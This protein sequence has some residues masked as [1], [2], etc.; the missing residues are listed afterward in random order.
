MGPANQS[1]CD[2][3]RTTWTHFGLAI[4]GFL[5]S[6]PDCWRICTCPRLQFWPPWYFIS[7]WNTLPVVVIGALI[8]YS[9]VEMWGKLYS[10]LADAF[11]T[12]QLLECMGQLKRAQPV[13]VPIYD[14]KK[15][16]WCSESF[17]KVNA[18]DVIIL[19][20]I[21]VFHDQRVRDL[22]DMKIFVDTGS[23]LS[24]PSLC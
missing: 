2:F 23:Y 12:E 19:E 22:M 14:F 3:G 11:D 1:K 13:N 6:G 18:S 21:L 7:I 15:H 4:S 5:L 20:G 16:R 8:D 10:F 17:R 24:G 9:L